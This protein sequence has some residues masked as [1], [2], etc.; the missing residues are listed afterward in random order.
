MRRLRSIRRYLDELFNSCHHALVK[1]RCAGGRIVSAKRHARPGLQQLEDRLAPAVISDGGSAILAISL[2]QQESLAIVSNGTS[3]SLTSNQTFNAVNA[4]NPANAGASFSGLGS[5]ALTMTGAGLARYS[6]I[7]ITDAGANDSV[8]FSDSGT[9]AYVNSFNVH[10]SNAAAGPILFLG[11]T[12]FGA[13]SLD[14]T[15]TGFATIQTGISVRT[16][17][18]HISIYGNA[19]LGVDGTLTTVSGNL[20]LASIGSVVV[21]GTINGG[22]GILSVSG[23]FNGQPG[24]FNDG[25]LVAGTITSNG[26]NVQVA[27]THGTNAGVEVDSGGLITAGGLGSV[28]VSGSAAGGAPSSPYGVAMIGGTINSSGGDVDV[29]GQALEL[30]GR[31]RRLCH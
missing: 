8:T 30:G 25:V 17:S 6:R 12:D 10:L 7:D 16:G 24:G 13:A 15:T 27:G 14:A 5:H 23:Q 3:Y 9:N 11:T 21:R 18:G 28:T 1:P 4:A 19:G 22:T 26:G 29:T 20:T 2:Q 31:D